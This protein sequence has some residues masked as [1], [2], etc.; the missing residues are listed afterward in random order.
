[1]AARSGGRWRATSMTA[2]RS[3]STGARS[4]IAPLAGLGALLLAAGGA[5]LVLGRNRTRKPARQAS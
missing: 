1:M 4:L 2:R 3:A 5:V